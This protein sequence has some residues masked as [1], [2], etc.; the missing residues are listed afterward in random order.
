M[1]DS[2]SSGEE[3]AHDVLAA[4][5]FGVPAPD[6]DLHSSAEEAHDVLAAEEFAMPA[7]DPVL[8]VLHEPAHDVLAAEEFALPA[9]PGTDLVLVGDGGRGDAGG[10]ESSSLPER[11]MAV[12]RARLLAIAGAFAVLGA[13][14]VNRFL[15]RKP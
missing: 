2:R 12:S 6:P 9:G 13:W 5:E 7:P 11:A 14:V 15:R 10:D 1:A 8:H 4:E 3:P